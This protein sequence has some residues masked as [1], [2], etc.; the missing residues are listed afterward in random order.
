MSSCPHSDGH[1]IPTDQLRRCMATIF[2]LTKQC[3]RKFFGFFRW[4]TQILWDPSGAF[5]P[6]KNIDT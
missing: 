1:H 4:R 2:P 6:G 5:N 3:D